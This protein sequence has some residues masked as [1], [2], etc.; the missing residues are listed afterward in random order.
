MALESYAKSHDLCFRLHK[1]FQCFFAKQNDFIFVMPQT[2]MNLSG[3]ALK[4]V[5]GFYKFDSILVIC[6]DL[7]LEFG[8]LRFKQGGGS[9]GHNGIKSIIEHI[10]NDFLRLKIGIS[11]PR[12]IKNLESQDSIAQKDTLRLANLNI[13]VS[14]FVLS[15]FNAREMGLLSQIFIATDSAIDDFLAGNSLAFL[16]N[17]FNK[18]ALNAV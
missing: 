4:A 5:C 10:G 9:G 1:K 17:K 16:Q 3:L 7:D 11:H 18:S 14:D 6:D 15:D 12:N 2:F 13:S 8:I